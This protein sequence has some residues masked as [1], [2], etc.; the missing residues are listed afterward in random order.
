[1]KLKFILSYDGSA[2]LGSATQPHQKSVQDTLAE[3]LKHLG[4]NEKPLFASRTDK[5]VHSLGNVASV[6]CG[7]HFT[8]F[9]YMQKK[10]NK[11]L[12]PFMMIKKIQCVSDEFQVRFDAKKRVY[13]YL[14]NHNNFNPLLSRFFHFYP[15]IDKNEAAAL[16]RLFEGEHDFRFFCKGE[17]KSTKR[18]IFSAKIYQKNNLSFIRF[19]ANGFLRSQIRLMISALLKTLEAKLSQNELLEQI[20]GKKR[21][22]STLAPANGLYLSRIFY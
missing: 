9:F 6:N 3:A 1:M 7:E 8:D 19:C 22:S 13:L 12:A 21:H 17:V 10:L 4:I 16:L 18:R 5:G 2:F 20:E 11:H 15:K 14:L